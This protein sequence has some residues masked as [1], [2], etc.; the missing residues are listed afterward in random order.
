MRIH[1]VTEKWEYVFPESSAR[2]SDYAKS[3]SGACKIN[4]ILRIEKGMYMY[5]GTAYSIVLVVECENDITPL[6]FNIYIRAISSLV[7]Y[8]A[9][10]SLI[11]KE[12]AQFKELTMG[13][14]KVLKKRLQYYEELNVRLGAVPQVFM[15]EKIKVLALIR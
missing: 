14:L 15:E 13:L 11:S 7:S 3:K 1:V 12:N 6:I 2:V 10:N 4:E 8:E 5:K 9:F